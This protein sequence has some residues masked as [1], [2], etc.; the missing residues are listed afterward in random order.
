M[1]RRV[2]LRE[3]T[4]LD[5]LVNNI[6]R[7]FLDVDSVVAMVG[8]ARYFIVSFFHAEAKFVLK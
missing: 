5:G 6:I 2:S 8:F 4:R 3:E 7:N 1:E